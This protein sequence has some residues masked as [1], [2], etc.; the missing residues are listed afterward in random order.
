MATPTATEP[1]SDDAPATRGRGPQ[2]SLPSDLADVVRGAA[3]GDEQAWGELVTR[4]EPLLR[5]IARGYRLS[6][7]DAD[8]VV[9]ATW[10]TLLNH[11]GDLR[12]PA[13]IPGW[14]ATTARRKCI[15]KLRSPERERLSGEIDIP[16]EE[17]SPE[18][19]L[20]SA[21]RRQTVTRA[22]AALPD[23]QRVL[24]SLLMQEPALAYTQIAAQLQM[25]VGSI[26]PTWGRCATKLRQHGELARLRCEA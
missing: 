6:A 19:I 24:V 17:A 22:V 11:I 1:V 13:R 23:R 10:L 12:D 4:L 2:P 16:G 21:E 9:Q 7:S 26:G 3:A 15:S 20:I 25:P 18:Q 5:R 8:D 14:L